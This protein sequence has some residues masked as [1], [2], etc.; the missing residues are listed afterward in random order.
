MHSHHL[1]E[2]TVLRELSAAEETKEMLKG[3]TNCYGLAAAGNKSATRLPL[4]PLGCGGE[5]KERGR[6]W[7][8]GIKAV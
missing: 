5:W 2:K 4:P 7:W 8:V 6:N 3:L 1:G